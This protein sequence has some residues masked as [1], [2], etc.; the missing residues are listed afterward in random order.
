VIVEALREGTP[1]VA[2]RVSGHPE[3]IE[4][5]VSGRL[6][7]PDDPR[8]LAEA[9]VELLRDPEARDRMGEAGRRR[10]AERF[11]AERQIDAYVDYYRALSGDRGR[12]ASGDPG[13]HQETS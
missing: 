5:G 10:V 12:R 4:D 8:A 7:P 13:R 3:V 6:V 9:C 11:D 1:V 2:T